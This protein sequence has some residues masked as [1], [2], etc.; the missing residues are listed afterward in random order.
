G[1]GLLC[2]VILVIASKVM[3]VKEDELF[4][5][6]RACLPGANCGACGYP[7]CDGYAKALASGAETKSNLCV[8]GADATA[9]EVAGVLGVEALDVIEMV[10]VVHCSGDCEHTKEK[11]D[12]KGD[13][14]CKSMKL[15]F[16]GV[17]ACSFACMGGGDCAAVCPEGAITMEKGIAKINRDICGGCGMCAKTCPAGV[18][19]IVP[20]TAPLVVACH[21]TAKGAITRKACTAGCIGCGKCQKSCPSEAIQVVNNLAVVDYAKCTGCGTCATDCPTKCLHLVNGSIEIEK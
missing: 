6:L 19:T 16:G 7:G 21:S 17:G 20:T 1:L 18:I 4:A 12:Y 10:A 11:M 8:P 3:A 15:Y 13:R 9:A 5:P 14:S 2:A